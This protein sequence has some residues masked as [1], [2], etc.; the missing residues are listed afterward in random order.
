MNKTFKIRLIYGLLAAVLAFSAFVYFYVYKQHRD[1][2]LEQPAYEISAKNLVA[3]FLSNNTSASSKYVD[4]T[5]SIYGNIT[6][7]DLTSNTIIVDEKIVVV[8]L[9]GQ[10]Q[11]LS[12]GENQIIK[13]RLVGFDDLFEEIKMDQ[14]SVN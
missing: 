2:S 9:E 11:K 7:L 12:V 13:G 5:I 1:I 3:E 4:Q 10:I 6:S 14:C 8:L